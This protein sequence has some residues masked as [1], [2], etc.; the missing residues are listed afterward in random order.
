MKF[1]LIIS[2]LL[3]AVLAVTAPYVWS[4]E[5]EHEDEDRRPVVTAAQL[6]NPLY[7]EEC[8][9]CHMAYPPGLLPTAS[10]QKVMK[11]LDNHFGDNAELD[12]KT[13]QSILVFL[14]NNSADK[15]SDRRFRQFT[16]NNDSKVPLRIT[17][18]P[19]FKDEHA[20]IPPRLVTGNEAVRSFSHCN[21]C[22]RKAEQ[23]SFR[24]RDIN[25]PGYG[26]WDD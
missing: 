1:I 17:Q 4:D 15:T 25:I 21:A 20:D 26:R 5:D 19:Y 18:T 24:E 8:G 22:H 14:T 13:R 11:N 3:M 16:E 12:T 7:R 10:W 9:S 23:G 2:G 6:N